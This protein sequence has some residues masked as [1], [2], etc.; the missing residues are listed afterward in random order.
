MKRKRQIGESAE[1]CCL[2]RN[3]KI[4]VEEVASV[5]W[6]M[7]M[8]GPCTTNVVHVNN[9]MY[10]NVLKSSHKPSGPQKSHD[11]SINQETRRSMSLLVLVSISKPIHSCP[12]LQESG[13]VYQPQWTML[14]PTRHLQS[15]H[16]IALRS[17]LAP[18]IKYRHLELLA[19]KK[20][21]K[22][23]TVVDPCAVTELVGWMP[24]EI[25]MK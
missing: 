20:N 3:K 9:R 18:A 23:K 19:R 2:F 4:M 24:V 7:N 5:R 15:Y 12:G 13:I 6:F 21:D 25:N 10:Y 14:T 17:K 16:Q 22:K 11:Y 8:N 1:K